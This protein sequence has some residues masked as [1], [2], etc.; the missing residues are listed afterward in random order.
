[1][2]GGV[3]VG[4]LATRLVV[5][6]AERAEQVIP[7][8][9]ARRGCVDMPRRSGSVPLPAVAGDMCPPGMSSPSDRL[10]AAAIVR[11][12][13][14]ATAPLPPVRVSADPPST[15]ASPDPE[16]RTFRTGILT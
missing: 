13:E 9:A 5:A 6:D 15:A 7:P 10:V 14:P 3:P 1:V 16:P 2:E 4:E 11:R 8:V 12:A